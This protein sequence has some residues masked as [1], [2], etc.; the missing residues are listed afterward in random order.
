MGFTAKRKS[1]QS[2]KALLSVFQI[3][4]ITGFFSG[5]GLEIRTPGFTFVKHDIS[6]IAPLTTR[7]TLQ[8]NR[9]CVKLM[10]HFLFI[11]QLF[12]IQIMQL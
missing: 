10:P 2:A 12:L 8:I 3:D 5:G 9:K 7:T 1:L 4:L 6:S 11:I